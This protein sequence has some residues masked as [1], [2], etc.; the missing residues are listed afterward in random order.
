MKKIL[1]VPAALFALTFT[2]CRETTPAEEAAHSDQTAVVVPNGDPTAADLVDSAGNKLDRAGDN[3]ADAW[4]DVDWNAP[5][6]KDWTEVND[7]D[8]EVRGNDRYGIYSMGED[9]MFALNSA[10][11]SAAAKKKVSMVAK[12]INQ[13]FNGATVRVYG[14]TDVTGDAAANMELSK[15]RAE[16]VRAQLLA[17]GLQADK[18]TVHGLG[19]AGASG[20]AN[21]ADRRVKIVARK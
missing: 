1:L 13:R 8:V 16:A 7:K 4:N 2:A 17:D 6:T 9:V 21:M 15:K 19:E 18:V 3:V 20:G 11:L 12:S 5:V 14:M 10:D